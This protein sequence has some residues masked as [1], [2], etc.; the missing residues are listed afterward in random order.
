MALDL[1]RKARLEPGITKTKFAL[2]SQNNS[3]TASFMLKIHQQI[4]KIYQ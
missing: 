2:A 1:V 4:T 3:R